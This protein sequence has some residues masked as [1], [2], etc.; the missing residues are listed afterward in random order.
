MTGFTAA[1]RAALDRATVPAMRS[2][3]AAG[4]VSA[5][6]A[7]GAVPPRRD[8]RSG[9]RR[10]GRVLIGAGAL[11]LASATAAATGWLGKLPLHIPGI[12]RAAPEPEAK[13]KRVA[14][15]ERPR[16]APG[17]AAAV[18][19]AAPT[20]DASP[21]PPTPWQVRRAER[22]AA[23]LPVRRP[24]MQRAIAE[25]LRAM[26]PEQRKAAIAEWRRIKA[27][28]PAERKVAMARIRGDYLARRPK[29]A[30]RFEQRLE[31]KSADVASA[32]DPPKAMPDA[33]PPAFGAGPRPLL[34]PEERTQRRDRRRA[35]RQWRSGREGTPPPA[36]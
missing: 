10:H 21:V 8:T 30:A 16:P 29:L 25:K 2:G 6:L 36:R 24:L 3:F 4:V 31:R 27:L 14:R 33:R 32:G 1:E 9:W 15:V 23:G 7:T 5:A 11:F 34:S 22:I 17:K 12:S 13:P 19:I 35:W 26:P 18:P 20:P 28:P